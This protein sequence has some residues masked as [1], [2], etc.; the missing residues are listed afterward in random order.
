M[1]T[2]GIGVGALVFAAAT[3]AFAQSPPT[4][5]VAEAPATPVRAPDKAYELGVEAGYTQGFG[6]FVADPRVGAGPGA[7]V[8][9]NIGYRIDPHWSV[10]A[11]GQYQGFGSSG[12]RAATLRGMTADFQGTYHFRPYDRLDPYVAFGAGYRLF[13]ESPAGNAPATLTHGIELGRVQVGLDVRPS[14]SVAVSPVI[15]VD[16][17]L[18]PWRSGGGPAA[19]QPTTTSPSAFVF[20]GVEGRFDVGGGRVNRPAP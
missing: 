19:A 7:T 18:F 20:A 3:Q 4:R 11:S 17:N 1:K 6:S 13:A 12:E 2:S 5:D 9:A 10:G 16:L 8:G 14:E 15:G